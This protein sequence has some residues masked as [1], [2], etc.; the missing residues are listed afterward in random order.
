MEM[1][2][3]TH[4]HTTFSIAVRLVE[5]GMAVPSAQRRTEE[6]INKVSRCS[7]KIVNT[8]FA[9]TVE[10]RLSQ[11]SVKSNHEISERLSYYVA[12]QIITP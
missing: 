7:T 6:T 9:E 10:Q 2:T 11:M 5:Q 4:T 8:K 1:R 12:M 3:N